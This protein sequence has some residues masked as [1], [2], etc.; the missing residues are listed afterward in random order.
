MA[1]GIYVIQNKI[2][3]KRYI[4]S[5]ARSIQT[6]FNEHRSKLLKGIHPNK[7]LQ[8]SVNKYGIDNFEFSILR[9]CD[10]TEVLSIEQEFLDR[11]KPEYNIRETAESNLGF[12]QTEEF[13]LRFS[14]AMKGVNNPKADKTI[15]TF[16]NIDGII[17]HC[18]IYDLATKYNLRLSGISLL[19]KGKAKQYKGWYKDNI[20]STKTENS[21]NLPVE[22]IVKLYL[23]GN[24]IFSIAKIHKVHPRTIKS[25]LLNLNIKVRQASF[26]Y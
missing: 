1:C 17:E 13:K 19:S 23:E 8:S 24:S 26:Y 3:D 16:I 20:K 21:I 4:G 18:N 2:N 7:H 6:R 11:L 14:E 10:A 12:K 25:R 9:Y 5:T 22:E 15:Y